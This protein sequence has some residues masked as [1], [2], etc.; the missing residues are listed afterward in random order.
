MLLDD[1]EY[2]RKCGNAQISR[3][4]EFIKYVSK[5]TKRTNKNPGTRDA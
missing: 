2:N 3:I 1:I 4:T 5:A